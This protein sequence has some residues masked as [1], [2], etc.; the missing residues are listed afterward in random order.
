MNNINNMIRDGIQT[1]STE[2][3]LMTII[4][5]SNI[6]EREIK[7]LKN[8][9]LEI[10]VAMFDGIIFFLYKFG[11]QHWM[12]APYS[13]HLANADLQELD[14][15]ESR[16]LM[17][18]RIIDP[19]RGEYGGRIVT[20]SPKMSRRLYKLVQEQKNFPFSQYSHDRSIEKTYSKYTTNQMVP[21]AYPE[22]TRHMRS[23]DDLCF[24]TVII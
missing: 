24:D 7:D 21:L 15:D 14:N 19:L 10:R 13:I 8:G 16:Y 11:G 3:G 4:R 17:T 9:D 12:D 23:E 18:I 5:F 20:L 6:T 1:D 2:H 22:R